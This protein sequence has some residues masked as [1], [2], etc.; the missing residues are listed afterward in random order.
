MARLTA[1]YR[2]PIKS[3]GRE[4][5]QQVTLR[6]GQPLPRDRAW[7]VLHEA[8]EK[9]L[10]DGQLTKWLPKAAFLRGAAAPGLQAVSGGYEGD[11]ITL[12]HPDL[13]DL[14]FDPG[15]EGAALI[16]WIAPL[17]PEDKPA[18]SQLIAGPA[19]LADQRNPLISI[20]STDSLRDLEARLGVRLG[21]D[22]WRGNLW[23]TGWEPWAE[24]DMIGAH[25][26]IGG[27]ELTIR[28][29]IGRCPA[30]SVDCAT[31]RLD[32]DMPAALMREIGA[33]DFGVFAEV[34]TGGDLT[35]EDEVTLIP[36]DD[37]EQDA[38]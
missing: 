3:I 12:T 34:I 14:R 29:P 19:P 23:V 38:G 32:G 33:S 28:E 16:D 1:I 20:L 6:P 9:H 30:T 17:W 2:H 11:A 27:A 26:R 5:M 24:R 36:S 37:T 35:L 22:R 8:A 31:G 15:T 21:Q 4:P 25:L 7:A 18:P 13:P 10:D